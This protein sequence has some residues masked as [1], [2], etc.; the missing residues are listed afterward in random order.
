[1]DEAKYKTLNSEVFSEQNKVRADPTSYVKTLQ[2]MLPLF[3]DKVYKE[4][5]KIAITTQEG[6]AAVQEAI[7]YLGKATAAP[8]KLRR[9][10]TDNG[11]GP[12]TGKLR[13]S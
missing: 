7:D 8:A 3:T 9:L 13:H 2:A 4:D 11:S 10:S 12:R 6:A 5:G 1:M